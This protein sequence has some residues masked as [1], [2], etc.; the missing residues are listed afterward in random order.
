[1]KVNTDYVKIK[2]KNKLYLNCFINKKRTNQKVIKNTLKNCYVVTRKTYYQ[3]CKMQKID[4]H[5]NEI[6]V[7]QFALQFI[8]IIFFTLCIHKKLFYLMENNFLRCKI[9]RILFK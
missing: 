1:M 3:F 8:I 7:Q 5:M 6:I 9:L 2:H 4:I